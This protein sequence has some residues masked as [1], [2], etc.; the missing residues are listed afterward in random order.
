M[1]ATNNGGTTHRVPHVDLVVYGATLRTEASAEPFACAAQGGDLRKALWRDRQ[2]GTD[3][4]G[5]YNKGRD[6]ALAVA[7]G[8]HF[9]H[10]NNVIHR[11]TLQRQNGGDSSGASG[12]MQPYLPAHWQTTDFLPW[13]R[14]PFF[15]RLLRPG[16]GLPGPQHVALWTQSIAKE[17]LNSLIFCSTGSI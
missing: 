12:F 2:A 16:S 14:D 17:R 10:C 13:V 11:C 4:W 15:G 1:Q 9:L 7:R 5:W 8:L 3:E 6:V